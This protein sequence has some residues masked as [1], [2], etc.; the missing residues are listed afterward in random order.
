VLIGDADVDVSEIDDVAEI[1]A[2]AVV[3]LAGHDIL[4][5]SPA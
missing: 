3:L 1:L 5:L 4:A 2:G